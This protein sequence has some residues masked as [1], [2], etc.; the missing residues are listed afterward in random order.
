MRYEESMTLSI[1]RL[2]IC[3]FLFV[4][5]PI[6]VHG[7]TPQTVQIKAIV[8]NSTLVG[9]NLQYSVVLPVDYDATTTRYPVLY[10][11]HGLFGHSSDWLSNG[12]LE[13]TPADRSDSCGAYARNSCVRL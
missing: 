2:F 3:A 7:Q 8:L 10:L 1:K 9:K 5:I 4:S 12:R 6:S 13:K 11:L